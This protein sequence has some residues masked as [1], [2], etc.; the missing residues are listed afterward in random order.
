[1]EKFVDTST[2]ALQTACRKTFKTLST[3]N[4]I[5]KKKSVPWWTDNLTTMQKKTNALRRLY[6]RTR[7]NEELRVSR[8]QIYFEAKKKYPFEIRK[9][10]F[11]S[12]K[13]YCNLTSS[14]KPW[15]QVY[16]LATGKVRSIAIMT[17]LRKPDGT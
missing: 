2:E 4:K 8:K 10:K 14:S 9:E 17:T 16:K 11:N 13:E 5:G 15:S 12:W 1:L 7:N 3:E 6:Q